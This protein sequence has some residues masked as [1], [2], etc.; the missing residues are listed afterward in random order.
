MKDDQDSV[1]WQP[2]FSTDQ[3]HRA[4]IVK[5]VLDEHHMNP[6]LINKKDSSYHNFGEIEVHVSSEFTLRARQ[7]I[8]ND[9]DFE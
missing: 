9:I 6:V 2:V 3:P 5:A 1:D 4:E 8:E 7:I